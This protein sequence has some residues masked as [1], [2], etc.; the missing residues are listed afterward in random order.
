MNEQA[1]SIIVKILGLDYKVK[2]PSDKITE[3]QEAA[4]HLDNIMQEI[5]DGSNIVSLDRVAVVAALNVTHEMLTLK[6]Q[7]N[8]YIELLNQR[9]QELQHKIELALASE[10]T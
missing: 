4:I 2:C 8:A 10:T 6:R 9:I 5:R 3:L 7:K 1:N